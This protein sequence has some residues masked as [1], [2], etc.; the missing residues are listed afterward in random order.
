MRYLRWLVVPAMLVTVPGGAT[1]GRPA[2]GTNDDFRNA[3]AI[4]SLPFT[5]A[6]DTS[7][8]TLQDGEPAPSCAF[9]LDATLWYSFAPAADTRVLA[10]TF[11]SGFDTVVAVYTG[12][13][14]TSLTEAACNDDRLATSQSGIAFWALARTTYHIQV[15]GAL[16]DRGDLVLNLSV[17]SP[18]RREY[19]MPGTGLLLFCG[20][21]EPDTGGACF[22][23]AAGDATVDLEVA[24][25]QNNP[26]GTHY[27]FRDEF[28][29][30]VARGEFCQSI[31]GIEVPGGVDWI[32][33]WHGGVWG[34]LACLPDPGIATTGATTAT[35]HR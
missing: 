11:G 1:A 27:E 34:P 19:A 18:E 20:V 3:K 17:G 16:G 32:R 13:R 6:A 23:V 5:D 9:D 25:D 15:G 35:F 4:S 2:T 28:G 10:N 24:D 29:E 26:V 8:A 12:R 21:E 14:L 7:D 30:T 31:Q 22:D 33:M